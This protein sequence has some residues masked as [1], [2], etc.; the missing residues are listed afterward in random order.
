MR[1]FLNPETLSFFSF[2]NCE[3]HLRVM[4]TRVGCMEKRPQKGLSTVGRD[5]EELRRPPQI[6][7]LQGWGQMERVLGSMHPLF[8]SA[9][10]Q[11]AKQEHR[12]QPPHPIFPGCGVNVFWGFETAQAEG[13]HYC[14]L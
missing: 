7:S 12:G 1:V 8:L 5:R 2:L 13:L 10:G 6:H 3:V 14:G 9:A 4:K 11:E